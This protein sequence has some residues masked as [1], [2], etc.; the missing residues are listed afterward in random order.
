M[1]D[2]HL[3]IILSV[4]HVAQLISTEPLSPLNGHGNRLHAAFHPPFFFGMP[5]WAKFNNP[6]HVCLMARS[7]TGN[8][9]QMKRSGGLLRATAM[10]AHAL[11]PL[12]LL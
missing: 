8:D 12:I 3:F 1:S 9:Q 10:S 2:K 7:P 4:E 6:Q 5:F 11:P